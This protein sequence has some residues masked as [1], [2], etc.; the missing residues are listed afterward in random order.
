MLRE[1]DMRLKKTLLALLLALPMVVVAAPAGACDP[2][3][4]NC[5][6]GCEVI[7]KTPIVNKHVQCNT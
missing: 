3:D 5:N 2:G 1:V 4:P 7:N 6:V